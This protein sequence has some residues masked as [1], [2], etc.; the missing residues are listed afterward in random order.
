MQM[1]KLKIPNEWIKKER[2]YTKLLK[3]HKDK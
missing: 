1:N 2:N 3:E